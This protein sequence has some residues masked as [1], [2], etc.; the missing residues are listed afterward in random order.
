MN[1]SVM[2]S[3]LLSGALVVAGCSSKGGSKD[4]ED[5]TG[6]GAG[7]G[8]ETSGFGGS[9][10]SA[11]QLRETKVIY[12]DLDRTDIQ[13]RY[14]DVLRAHADQLSKDPDLSITLEGHCDERGSREYNIALGERRANAVRNF[15]QAEGVS[16]RQISTVSFGEERPADPGHYESAWALNRRGVILY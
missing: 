3:L 15:L 6:T 12:F 4:G 2:F 10:L 5:G 14:F 7:T 9:G 16:G 1:R 13:P 8:A 11:E